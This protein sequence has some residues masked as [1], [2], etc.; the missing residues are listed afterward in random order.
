[1]RRGEVWSYNPVIGRAGQSRTRLVVSSDVVNES[2]AIATCYALHV[3]DSDPTSL[4]AVQTAWGWAS[5][6]LLDRPPRS[7]LAERLGAVTP[8][9]MEAVDNALRAVLE[10]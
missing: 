5:A 7:L 10:L 6:L 1:M 3:I 2:D 8:E 9:Q 4:L